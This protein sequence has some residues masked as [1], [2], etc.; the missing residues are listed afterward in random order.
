MIYH[1]DMY[2]CPNALDEIENFKKINNDKFDY[3]LCDEAF[4]YIWHDDLYFNGIM[5]KI[6]SCIKLNTPNK[7]KRMSKNKKSPILKKI[8]NHQS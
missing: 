4:Y 3:M 7:T 1:A 2:L 5:D 6:K 8:Y